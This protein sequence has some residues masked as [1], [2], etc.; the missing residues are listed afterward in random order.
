MSL[1]VAVSRL[2]GFTEP[3]AL[4]GFQPQPICDNLNAART[5]FHRTQTFFQSQHLAVD[6]HPLKPLL[7]HQLELLGQ[8]HFFGERQ[9]EGNQR[10]GGTITGPLARL[11]PLQH[12]LPNTIRRLSMDRVSALT[13]MGASD[14]RPHDLHVVA[15]L[16]HGPHRTA[17]G[18]DRIAL[19]DG[20]RRRDILD[21]IHR[22][23]VHPVEELSSVGGERL[24]VAALP[25]RIEGIEGQRA[26]AGSAQTCHHDPLPQRQVE[27]E[28]L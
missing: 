19:L 6:H 27:V 24:D 16:R 25:L 9:L 11:H 1:T 10:I 22:G 12:R 7:G 20:D 8:P 28:T 13:A 17:C 21:P 14:V 4:S 5:R 18:T 23:L 3:I 2:T 15:N 26:F